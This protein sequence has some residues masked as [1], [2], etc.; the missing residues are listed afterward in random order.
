MFCSTFMPVVYI[1]RNYPL[2]PVN[3]PL[4]RVGTLSANSGNIFPA[5]NKFP[6]GVITQTDN[7]CDVT[8]GEKCFGTTEYY[9]HVLCL[10]KRMKKS[11]IFILKG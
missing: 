5:G 4:F 9:W 1:S 10:Q 2:I 8:V 3:I 6:L 7:I 11:V